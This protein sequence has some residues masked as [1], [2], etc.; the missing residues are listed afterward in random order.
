[1][2]ETDNLTIKETA[3]YL[4]LTPQSVW[5]AAKLGRL[6]AY[7]L[8]G[9]RRWLISKRELLAMQRKARKQNDLA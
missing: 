7:K 1:M 3:I 6:P 9:S 5:N 8:P 2:D 4:R